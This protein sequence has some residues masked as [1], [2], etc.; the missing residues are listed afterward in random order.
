MKPRPTAVFLFEGAL[1]GAAAV[2]AT[3]TMFWSDWI[4]LVFRI[5]PD[6]QSGSLERALVVTLIFAAVTLTV[7]ARV[8]WRRGVQA[9]RDRHEG[10]AG[11]CS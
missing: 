4:E 10:L 5:D 9:M 7:L 2:L 3:V 1:A 6:H 8:E 11:T